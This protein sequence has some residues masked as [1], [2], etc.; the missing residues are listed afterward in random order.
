MPDE[1]WTDVRD[2][3]EDA[4]TKTIRKKKK[5][6]MANGCLRAPYIY[7]WKED[8]QKTKEKGNVYPTEFQRRA[9]RYKKAFLSEQRKETERK[10]RMGKTRDLSK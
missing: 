6:K 7:L 2:I 8:K 10:N 4:V 9:R 3:V 5:S 1:L